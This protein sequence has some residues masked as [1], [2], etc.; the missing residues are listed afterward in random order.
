MENQNNLKSL[1][2]LAPAG[3]MERLKTALHFGADAVYFAGKS[4][5]LRAFS[6]NFPDAGIAEAV[7]CCHKAG[8]RAYITLN[9]FAHNADFDG[10]KGFL[11]ILTAASADAVIVS[12]PG[13]F[14]FVRKH[15]PGL[16]IHISTQANVT[17]A[18]SALFWA[19]QGA[20]RIVL[21]RELSLSEIKE[22]RAALPR[23]IELEAF[24]HGAMCISYSGRCLLSN[25]LSGRDGNRG[26]C[27]Q[28]C[29]WEYKMTEKQREGEPLTIQE[30]ARGTYIL[31]SRD[32][33]TLAILDKLAGAGIKSFKVEGRV[34][35]SFYVGSVINA[36]RRAL[37]L[38]AA[39]G[40]SDTDMIAQLQSELDKTGSRGFTGGF[41]LNGRQQKDMQNLETSKPQQE[42]VFAAVVLGYDK[43]RGAA[44]IEQRN[45]F[46]RGDI[47]EIVSPKIFGKSIK[48]HGM[49]DADGNP[50]T[51][52]LLVQQKLYLETDT[53][54]EEGD[55]LR[56]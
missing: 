16:D 47:L 42:A 32:L 8:A 43:K 52:A 38:Y 6:D 18:H 56:L 44:V 31:N 13:I 29:R 46:K 54:L 53:V 2:L 11:D 34:K 37:D 33:N 1:E 27:V 48:V 23:N 25:Y 51:D 40:F 39:G 45:R 55:I 21:A 36:Y 15:A 9:I 4:Y 20:R 3:N 19:A 14:A 7:R 17:N 26:E 41:Y 35:S 50:V 28:S 30:D 12:D 10:L 5:G 24:C 49:Y 22:I